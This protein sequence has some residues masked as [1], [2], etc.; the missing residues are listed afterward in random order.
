MGDEAGQANEDDE[1]FDDLIEDDREFY[2]SKTTLISTIKSLGPIKKAREEYPEIFR[3]LQILSTPLI[4]S[5]DLYPYH[6]QKEDLD[7][8]VSDERNQRNQEILELIATGPDKKD[9]KTTLTGTPFELRKLTLLDDHA[10]SRGKGL[11]KV[12]VELEDFHPSLLEQFSIQFLKEINNKYISTYNPKP[13]VALSA[14]SSAA[15][16]AGP[17]QITIDDVKLF[18][19]IVQFVDF[20]SQK[21]S[22]IFTD[23]IL[24]TYTLTEGYKINRSEYN[25]KTLEKAIVSHVNNLMSNYTGTVEG[26]KVVYKP[27]GLTE[28]ANITVYFVILDDKEKKAARSGAESTEDIIKFVLHVPNWEYHATDDRSIDYKLLMRK[29]LIIGD[30]SGNSIQMNIA[31]QMVKHFPTTFPLKTTGKKGSPSIPT[32]LVDNKYLFVDLYS[33]LLL[34][35]TIKS[36]KQ[37]P[38]ENANDDVAIPSPSR[39]ITGRIAKSASSLFKSISCMGSSVSLPPSIARQLGPEIDGPITKLNMEHILAVLG[40]TIGIKKFFTIQNFE[41]HTISEDANQDVNSEK[42]KTPYGKL[43]YVKDDSAFKPPVPRNTHVIS[44]DNYNKRLLFLFHKLFALERDCRNMGDTNEAKEVNDKINHILIVKNFL[45]KS[46]MAYNLGLRFSTDS[47][48]LIDLK[49]TIA[50]LSTEIIDLRSINEKLNEKNKL[51]VPTRQVQK[52]EL[53]NTIIEIR[54]QIQNFKILDEIDS[55]F[56]QNLSKNWD[57]IN[58]VTKKFIKECLKIYDIPDGT[59]DEVIEQHLKS[60]IRY[61][62]PGIFAGLATTSKTH[63]SHNMCKLIQYMQEV[64]EGNIDGINTETREL[65]IG[66][67]KASWEDFANDN[68]I[69]RIGHI[70]DY[71]TLLDI[72]I[73]EQQNIDNKPFKIHPKDLFKP[74]NNE[75]VH[76]IPIIRKSTDPHIMAD[77]TPNGN[78]TYISGLYDGDEL[79]NTGDFKQDLKISKPTELLEHPY[80]PLFEL[81]HIANYI[82]QYVELSCQQPEPDFQEINLLLFESINILIA[83]CKQTFYNLL[84]KNQSYIFNCHKLIYYI[85][86]LLQYLFATYGVKIVDDE[87]ELDTL[88]EMLDQI[89]SSEEVEEEGDCTEADKVKERGKY[90]FKSKID[91]K[92]IKEGIIVIELLQHN[93][94]MLLKQPNIDDIKNNL[95]NPTDKL[96]N[97][98]SFDIINLLYNTKEKPEINTLISKI[99]PEAEAEPVALPD[100]SSVISVNADAARK[101]EESA[102][103]AAMVDD[104]SPVVTP[105]AMGDDIPA[106]SRE[107]DATAAAMVDDDSPA[108]LPEGQSLSA[109]EAARVLLANKIMNLLKMYEIYEI[110]KIKCTK[111]KEK[112]IQLELAEELLICCCEKSPIIT[113]ATSEKL[114]ITD[115][116]AENALKFLKEIGTGGSKNQRGGAL[117]YPLDILCNTTELEFNCNIQ[118]LKDYIDY[119]KLYLDALNENMPSDKSSSIEQIIKEMNKHYDI[120]PKDVYSA[121]DTLQY[122]NT[123]FYEHMKKLLNEIKTYPFIAQPVKNGPVFDIIRSDEMDTKEKPKGFYGGSKNK[124]IGGT[125][126]NIKE[127]IKNYFRDKKISMYDIE[128]LYNYY[129]D[130]YTNYGIY[131]ISKIYDFIYTILI[132]HGIHVPLQLT[133]IEPHCTLSSL[134]YKVHTV[135]DDYVNSYNFDNKFGRGLCIKIFGQNLNYMMNQL[136]HGYLVLP[137]IYPNISDDMFNPTTFL[138]IYNIIKCLCLE[139]TQCTFL[140]TYFLQLNV[141]INQPYTNLFGEFDT[142]NSTLLEEMKKPGFFGAFK[143]LQKIH[144]PIFNDDEIIESKPELLQILGDEPIYI[145]TKDTID[146]ENFEKDLETAISKATRL[147]IECVVNPAIMPILVKILTIK[148]PTHDIDKAL[149]VLDEIIDRYPATPNIASSLAKIANDDRAYSCIMVNMIVRLTKNKP[150]ADGI[151]DA[152][153]SVIDINPN[154]VY[155]ALSKFP[156]KSVLSQIKQLYKCKDALEEFRKCHGEKEEEKYEL[157]SEQLTAEQQVSGNTTPNQPTNKV[158]NVSPSTSEGLTDAELVSGNTTPNQPT[159]PNTV[160]PETRSALPP[161]RDETGPAI[162][163]QPQDLLS[164][165]PSSLQPSSGDEASSEYEATSE[166]V[167]SDDEASPYVSDETGPVIVTQEHLQSSSLQPSSEDES[168]LEAPLSGQE[169]G[170]FNSLYGALMD[171]NNAEVYAL[172]LQKFYNI[173]NIPLSAIPEGDAV[174]V[175]EY[176]P[177]L[178]AGDSPL[179]DPSGIMNTVDGGGKKI[180]KQKSIK[181]FVRPKQKTIKRKII[182]EVK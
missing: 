169:I 111:H 101:A 178:T 85:K 97:Q 86:G 41:L 31:R 118:K 55:S 122:V 126:K 17:P 110:Q 120:N 124:Q 45:V 33:G 138:V 177:E 39:S 152:L 171:A 165:Q 146:I 27:P 50:I 112:K 2:N 147:R 125:P 9:L 48:E 123:N 3:K 143:F 70:N 168:S 140:H 73:E 59:S 158:T 66:N 40:S 26:D 134:L 175:P 6:I 78:G 115:V 10:T 72:I 20:L 5:I 19:H 159:N 127:I 142:V 12:R 36:P 69:K 91:N 74:I 180:T 44:Q 16:S 135:R 4:V 108:A 160:T 84:I 24:A 13:S 181:R 98:I 49:G 63:L 100:A 167:S 58:Q 67:I 164:S 92:K 15:S 104:D 139:F 89:A 131:K 173:Q 132:N 166:Y 119:L 121:F 68:A 157:P 96:T 75:T 37:Y 145:G 87:P 14:A 144:S 22:I 64:I 133:E 32:S 116:R 83:V 95:I 56:I 172:E 8:S 107:V 114:P 90:S 174:P 155:S 54:K 137:L 34:S 29:F 103:P 161:D 35:Q 7:L 113:D 62:I 1:Y 23:E 28:N 81:T 141:C 154:L 179:E 77:P 46:K 79:L 170:R 117:K 156:E 88:Q 109:A 21:C 94:D 80:R 76:D 150:D 60:P 65:G 38:L 136:N 61:T 30:K 182:I 18:K 102:A 42:Y 11:S 99:A 149:K 130:T 105:E 162:V 57:T 82:I 148:H 163:T 93:L 52:E 128:Q 71:T 47:D 25:G 176:I 106:V 43:Q 129:M 53:D 153:S 151:Q 51:N